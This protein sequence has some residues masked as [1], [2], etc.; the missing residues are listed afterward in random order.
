MPLCSVNIQHLTL[1]M[2][3]RPFPPAFKLLPHL[4]RLHSHHG[5]P[6]E[7]PSARERIGNDAIEDPAAS[8]KLSGDVY[9]HWSDVGFG[10]EVL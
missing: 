6:L 5:R 2:Q 7:L 3:L 9:S 1:K 10:G 4:S 8:L